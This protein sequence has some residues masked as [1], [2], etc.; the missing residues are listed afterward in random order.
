MAAPDYRVAHPVSWTDTSGMAVSRAHDP[1][2]RA[3]GVP[4]LR[5]LYRP[6]GVRELRLSTGHG[7]VLGSEYAVVRIVHTAARSSGE[8]WL[9]RY[10][11]DSAADWGARGLQA[12]RVQLRPDPDWS[13]IVA[14]LD[15][16]G[17]STITQPT[18]VQGRYLD[19]GDLYVEDRNGP[20]YRAV[21][22]NAPRILARTDPTARPAAAIAALV[23]SLGRAPR[24]R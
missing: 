12:R 18:G 14:R 1:I 15:G 17:L 5:G 11:T 9:Y 3:L 19:A 8:V 4:A 6:E 20:R 13:A 21:W 2:A 23:D 22:I 7:M 10:A 16:L 24:A